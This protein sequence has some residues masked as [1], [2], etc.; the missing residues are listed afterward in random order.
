MIRLSSLNRNETFLDSHD[1]CW[2]VTALK[3]YPVIPPTKKKYT[4]NPGKYAGVF[5]EPVEPP[6][7]PTHLHVICTLVGSNPIVYGSFYKHTRVRRKD[8]PLPTYPPDALRG[9][10]GGESKNAGEL[11]EMGIT[12]GQWN[13][14]WGGWND[15]IV[16]REAFERLDP[17]WGRFVWKL[18]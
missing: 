2:A 3:E 9:W 15:C 17:L 1:R 7:A 12:L 6:T 4:R 18:S 14:E 11:V 16:T 10:I 8:E 5:E 13:D